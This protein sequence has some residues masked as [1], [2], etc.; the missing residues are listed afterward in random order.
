ML[1]IR[2]EQ[3][4]ALELHA[5]H[6]FRKRLR[7]H[8]SGILVPEIDLDRLIERGLSDAPKFYLTAERDVARFVEIT[9]LYL[10]GFPVGNLPVPA[11]AILMSYGMPASE[12]LCHYVTWARGEQRD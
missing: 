6:Q 12:K 1:T 3:I 4:K 11:L 5:V 8:L 7:V 10:G 2:L 9:G